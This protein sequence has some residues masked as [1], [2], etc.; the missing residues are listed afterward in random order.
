MILSEKDKVFIERLKRLNYVLENEIVKIHSAYQ[1]DPQ[2]QGRR[3]P[4]IKDAGSKSIPGGPGFRK[5]DQP[6]AHCPSLPH[7]LAG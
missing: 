2:K 4:L 7:R 6:A 5:E 3:R 1:R